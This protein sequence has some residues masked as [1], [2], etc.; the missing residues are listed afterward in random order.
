M[1]LFFGSRIESAMEVFASIDIL[2]KLGR[3]G[4]SFAESISN[5]NQRQEY[6]LGLNLQSKK[7]CMKLTLV[8][9]SK[10]S[11]NASK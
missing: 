5:A 11:R 3:F 8:T 2:N 1:L 7:P 10:I 4:S 6:I 9:L